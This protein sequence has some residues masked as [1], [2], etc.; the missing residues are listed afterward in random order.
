MPGAEVLEWNVI[1]TISPRDEMVD[2]DESRYLS[3]GR[4]A[5]KCVEVSLQSAGKNPLSVRRILD[6]PCGHG[7]VLR[8]LKA[9]FPDAELTACDTL[10]DGVDFCAA[11]FG[12]IPVYS[13]DDPARIPI[14]PD[15]FDLI[16]VGS[17]FTHFR[18][19]FWQPFLR[20]FQSLLAPGGVLI[21]STHGRQVHEWITTK[22]FYG[23][24]DEG[25]LS[26]LYNF[27]NGGFGYVR[28]PGWETDYGVSV[29]DP[30]WVLR[31]LLKIDGLRI[32]HFAERSL[33]N[34]HDCFACVR[35]DGWLQPFSRTPWVA[36]SK[37]KLKTL[38]RQLIQAK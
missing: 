34:H 10:R 25:K 33:D 4:S 15:Q 24:D 6:L 3:V 28:Y 21:F 27:E 26:L 29:S 31:E 32:V 37:M 22:S 12:A 1:R 13:H 5:M 11:E 23:V 36:Y 30:A 20:F 17:L 38:L 19:S 9:G 16:W 14:E 8:Y 2:G 35:E 18:L 7:R